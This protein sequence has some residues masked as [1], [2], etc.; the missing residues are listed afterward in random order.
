[1]GRKYI[2]LILTTILVLTSCSNSESSNINDN[3]LFISYEQYSDLFKNISLNLELKGYDEKKYTNES[4]LI[5]ID[6][7]FSFGKREYL[8][9]DGEQ[10]NTETQEMII[11]S[12]SDESKYVILD[13]MYIKAHLEKDLVYI[14][15]KAIDIPSSTYEKINQYIFSYYNV[16]IKVTLVNDKEPVSFEQSYA[17]ADSILDFLDNYNTEFTGK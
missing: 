17:V 5:F 3:S 6:K 1:M 15:S 10:S 13:L 14:K 4:N 11:F 8:T 12:N 16:L 2:L 7:H 9:L